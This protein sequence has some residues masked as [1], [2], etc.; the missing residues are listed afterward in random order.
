MHPGNGRP[1]SPREA[2]ILGTPSSIRRMNVAEC[3]PELQPDLALAMDVARR[4]GGVIRRGFGTTASVSYK[5]PDQPVTEVDRAADRIIREGLSAARPEY[6]W[7]SEESRTEASLG[8]APT[9]VVDPL[10]GTVNFV[11]DRPEFAVCIGLLDRGTPT[12]GVVY[13]PMTDEMYGACRGGT[14]FRG[15][16]RI[17]AAATSPGKPTLAA[18]WTEL[19]DGLLD[20]F[21]EGWKAVTVGSTA[22]KVMRVAEGL[23]D[24]YVSFGRKEVWDICAPAVIAEA[25]GAELL[26][27]DG[28]PLAWSDD[29]DGTD[30]LIVLGRNRRQELSEILRLVQDASSSSGKGDSK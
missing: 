6:G 18:S 12:L 25:A 9:W 4:A 20:C 15:D 10:D 28:T 23:V 27:L 5:S 24:A 26:D 1:S 13:N 17:R 14:A 8:D 2:V 11:Q 19:H 3:G 30:G 7:I 21:V 29:F 22:L 16:A